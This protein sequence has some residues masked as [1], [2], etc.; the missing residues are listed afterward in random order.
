MRISRANSMGAKRNALNIEGSNSKLILAIVCTSV[1]KV[2]KLPHLGPAQPNP[3][4]IAV[5]ANIYRIR[6]EID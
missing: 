1:E 5:S 4:E 6:H 2:A 3:G